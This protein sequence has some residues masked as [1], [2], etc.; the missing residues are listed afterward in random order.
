MNSEWNLNSEWEFEF[1]VG[2]L[3]RSGNLN[4]EWEFEFGVGI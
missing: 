2:I 3:I 1:G 4:S